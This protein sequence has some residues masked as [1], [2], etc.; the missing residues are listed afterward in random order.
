MKTMLKLLVVCLLLSSIIAQPI[1]CNSTHFLVPI[2]SDSLGSDLNH[3]CLLNRHYLPNCKYY[4][5]YEVPFAA[6]PPII[7]AY[8]YF[9]CW[10]CLP[11]FG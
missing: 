1:A 7:P 10:E 8:Y 2:A 9:G 11:G 3:Q 4:R 6:G 5:K